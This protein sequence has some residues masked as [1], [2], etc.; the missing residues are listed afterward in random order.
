MMN[1]RMWIQKTISHQTTGATPYNFSFSPPAVRKATAYYGGDSIKERLDFPIRM[2]GLKTIKPLY[3]SP[4]IYGE[5]IKDEFGVL[6]ATN[7]RDRG[8][9]IGPCLTEPDLS[10]YRFP[11]VSQSYRFK[12][13]GNWCEENSEHYTIIWI[14]DLWER[15]TFMRGMEDLCEDLM[16]HARFVERLLKHI[17]E[18]I[19]ETMERGILRM[20]GRLQR[21]GPRGL[22]VLRRCFLECRKWQNHRSARRRS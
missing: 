7:E 20:G 8:A 10:H 14:G 21:K 15:A 19:L 11:D 18:Y 13:L 17:A 16:L 3:A 2:T 5:T 4:E 9:P 6:W 12:K 22:G 1:N